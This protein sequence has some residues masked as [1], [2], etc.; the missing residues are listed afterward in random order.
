MIMANDHLVLNEALETICDCACLLHLARN[1]LHWLIGYM[2]AQN[3]SG[4]AEVERARAVLAAIDEMLS[5]ANTR[6][7]IKSREDRRCKTTNDAL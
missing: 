4:S 6:A 5:G 1:E 7:L 3:G 2:V